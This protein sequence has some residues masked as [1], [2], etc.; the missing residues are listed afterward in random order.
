MRSSHTVCFTSFSYS[1][2]SRARILLSTLRRNHPEWTVYALLTDEEPV[3]TS[4]S[5]LSEFDAVVNARELGY[6]RFLA[7]MFKH[8]VVEACTAVKARML[9]KLLGWGYEKVI[10]FDPDVALFSPINHVVDLLDTYSVVLTP[11]QTQPNSSDIAIRDNEITALQYG[12]YNLGFVA[13]KNDE[14]SIEFARWWDHQLH[15]AC[16]DDLVDGIFTDQKYV[17]L[18]P[19]IFDGVYINRDP[20]CNVASWNLQSAENII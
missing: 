11:H 14:N 1:Y 16:Y 10:Y 3:G 4:V 5:E 13:V 18:V 15:R 19:A 6:D 7:W 8:N 20:G 2:L 12:V 17:D 9:L